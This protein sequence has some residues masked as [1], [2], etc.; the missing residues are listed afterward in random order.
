MPGKVREVKRIPTPGS[1]TSVWCAVWESTFPAEMMIWCSQAKT[2][3]IAKPVE[4]LAHSPLQHL[5]DQLLENLRLLKTLSAGFKPNEKCKKP[6]MK[7]TKNSKA[8]FHFSAS[9]LLLSAF[10]LFQVLLVLKSPEESR[11]CLPSLVF[12]CLGKHT[13]HSSTY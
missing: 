12:S 13:V 9:S 10:P 8:C 1:N 2:H 3:W 11:Q 5:P 4:S 6:P 7:Y